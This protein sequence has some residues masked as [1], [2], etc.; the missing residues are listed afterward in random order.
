LKIDFI[1]IDISYAIAEKD[2]W[3][4]KNSTCE[5]LESLNQVKS[6]A[7]RR[8]WRN[9]P[10]K[11]DYRQGVRNQHMASC[12]PVIVPSAV[13]RAIR[14]FDFVDMFRI[15]KLRYR[16]SSINRHAFGHKVEALCKRLERNYHIRDLRG[17]T[18]GSMTTQKPRTRAGCAAY[19]RERLAGCGFLLKLKS[20][21]L[22]T[23]IRSFFSAVRCSKNFA[24]STSISRFFS[25][26]IV[27]VSAPFS[28]SRKMEAISVP[29]RG[30]Q[31]RFENSEHEENG[32]HNNQAP[33]P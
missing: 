23:S 28:S 32:T 7:K 14:D 24:I 22:I 13:C 6:A 31:Y 18:E 19:L 5:R 16:G 20:L 4:P 2:V 25:G 10:R 1:I 26:V 11:S 15:G 8:A 12:E 30:A 3:G 33:R 9:P 17:E 29:R 21:T 27:M